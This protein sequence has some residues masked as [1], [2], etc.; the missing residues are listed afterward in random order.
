VKRLPCS[1]FVPFLF[2]ACAGNQAAA[3]RAAATASP[4]RPAIAEH[5]TSAGVAAPKTTPG[6]AQAEDLDEYHLRMLALAQAEFETFVRKAGNDPR[7]TE[8]VRRSRDHIDDIA[9]T[10]EFLAAGLAEKHAQ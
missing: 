7:F 3:P 10:R 9:K 2:A 8:A 1:M 6:A 4:P 5:A